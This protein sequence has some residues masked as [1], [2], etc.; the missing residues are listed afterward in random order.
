MIQKRF[1]GSVDFYRTWNEYRN[2][3]GDPTGEFWLGNRYISL[4]TKEQ[5]NVLR[6]EL[7]SVSGEMRFTEYSEFEL[8]NEDFKYSFH[9]GAVSNA[10]TA[11]EY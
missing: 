11:G 6:V 2:G 4:I 3:F 8:H 7:T 10:S 1:N 9:K 5:R